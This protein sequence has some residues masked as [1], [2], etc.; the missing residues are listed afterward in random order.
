MAEWYQ[1]ALRMGSPVFKVAP[2]AFLLTALFIIINV[3][4]EMTSDARQNEGGWSLKKGG[5]GGSL[6]RQ[7]LQG[8]EIHDTKKIQSLIGSNDVVCY[9]VM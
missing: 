4:L 1:L 5:G 9:G 6:L 7:T 8:Q 2:D 3:S